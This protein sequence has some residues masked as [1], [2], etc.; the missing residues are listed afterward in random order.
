MRTVE[1]VAKIRDGK[2]EVPKEYLDGL[3]PQVRVI[4]REALPESIEDLFADFDGEYEHIEIDW[5]KP[6]GKE[7]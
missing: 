4:M 3:K 6:V 7:T 2:I 1:F 5:G